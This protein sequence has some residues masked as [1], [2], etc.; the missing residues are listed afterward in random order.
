MKKYILI[1]VCL[2]LNLHAKDYLIGSVNTAWKLIGKN[3]RIEVISVKDPKI[4]GITCYLSYA[5]KGG[6]SE[7]IGLEEDTSD[8]S[9]SCEQTAQKI[10]IKEDITGEE[11]IF[12]KRSSVL[13]KKTRIVRM[14]DNKNQTIVYLV[15]S[16]RL[17]DG[18]PQN[19]IT[20]VP[21]NQAAG[22]VC[23]FKKK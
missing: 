19:S 3:D 6:T 12:K 1:L 10:V 23:E 20:A 22:N 14:Y 16:D 5:K 18:S 2:M 8:A 17:I 13:F 9:V 15:Y 7:I 11:D 4:D 21:C